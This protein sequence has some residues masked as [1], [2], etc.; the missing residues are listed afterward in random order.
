MYASISTKVKSSTGSSIATVIKKWQF[1]RELIR[2]C[3][4]NV[5]E[6]SEENIC[7]ETRLQDRYELCRMSLAKSSEDN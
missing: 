5:K 7:E 4:L 2:I 1:E 6:D 3:H